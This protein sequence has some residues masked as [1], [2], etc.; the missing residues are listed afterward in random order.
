[1]RLPRQLSKLSFFFVIGAFLP[2]L[3]ASAAA[4]Q[5]SFNPPALRF[6][7]VIVGQTAMLSPTVTN[8]GS[9]SITLSTMT[10]N[11]VPYS[12]TGLR[13]PLTLVAG[14]SVSFTVGFVPTVTGPANG[15]IQFNGG[16]ATLKLSGWGES[17][18]S[19]IANPPNLPFG[20]VQT[21]NTTT[22]LVTLTNNES[23][24]ITISQQSTSA[25]FSTQGLSLPLTLGTGHSVTFSIIFSP[26]AIGPVIGWFEG[27]SAKNTGLIQ[28]PLTGTGTASGQL[29]VSPAS[30]NFGNVNV[31]SS[32][33]QAGTLSA[34]GASVTVS[35]ATSNSSEF[36]FSGLA[37]P[38][39]IAAGQSIEYRTTFTPQSSGSASATL[40]FVSN[41]SDPNA[42]ENLTG[43]GVGVHSYNVSLSW[44]AST[45][46]VSGYNVYRG[47]KSGGPYSKI[48][49]TLYPSTTYTDSTVATGQTY[50]YVT[51]AV[52]S[53][54]Q[55][56]A[57]SNQAQAVIP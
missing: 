2:L 8:T 10:V 6:G 45:S 47:T 39:T 28:I 17:Q 26:T 48:N 53:S 22:A 7:E 15:T 11:G 18:Q 55:E 23:S 19:L 25:T 35:S 9:T 3:H 57:Y 14:Q 27:L 44:N 38:T 42:S 43:T 1:M 31:G 46:A 20:N 52:D 51:T 12:A 30:I 54:G 49:S 33:S 40:S 4:R 50:Y 24:S 21:G 37:L 34:T 56:S 5:L 41:A 32:S 29:T 13:L 16:A 36:T